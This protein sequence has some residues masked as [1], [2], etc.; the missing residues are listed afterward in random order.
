[1]SPAGITPSQTAGPFFGP[2]LLRDDLSVLVGPEIEGDRIRV[3][4]RVLDGDAAPV[5]DAVIEIW[6]ANHTGRYN[7]PADRR[8]LSLDAGFTGFGR[9]G[10]DE[11]GCYRFETIRPGRVPFDAGRLQAPHL[12]VTVLARGLLNH[13]S[14]RIYFGGAAAET[15][16]NDA[17]PVLQCVPVDRRRTLIASG[18]RLNG[19]MAYRFDIVL[20]GAGETVFFNV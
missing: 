8:P 1:M 6:Q 10:T 9:T 15:E 12:C 13:L 11:A 7:H 4:G 16:I 18:S 3:E 14:T 17:D 2:C 19:L 5:P 20:R